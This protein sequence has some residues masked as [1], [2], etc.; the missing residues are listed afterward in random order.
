MP[1]LKSRW[2]SDDRRRFA[3]GDRL[4]ARKIPGKNKPGPSHD[5]WDYE[6]DSDEDGNSGG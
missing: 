3:D 6:P 1:P 5:E 4:R 2:S